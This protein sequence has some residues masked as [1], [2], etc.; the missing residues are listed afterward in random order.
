LI[1]FFLLLL[2]QVAAVVAVDLATHHSQA[3]QVAV[4]VLV[5]TME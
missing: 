1:L 4:P 5:L 2:L 3:V